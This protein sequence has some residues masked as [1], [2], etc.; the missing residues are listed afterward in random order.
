MT[1][2]ETKGNQG[3]S[4]GR[5]AADRLLAAIGYPERIPNTDE[6]F[7]LRVDGKEVF[8]EESAGHLVLSIT[9]TEDESMIPTLAAYA[10]GRMLREE[11]TLA[12]GSLEVWKFRSLAETASN[13]LNLQTSKLP[14]GAVFLWQDA[15]TDANDRTLL[16]LFETFT[17]S[18]DWWRA[19]VEER[20]KGDAVEISEAVIRP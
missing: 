11:A 5:N 20:G 8:V 13:P 15:P 12:F 19:R 6:L 16:R 18:C 1:E 14:S 9:L 17:D 3:R 2:M 4:V 10:A 7:T